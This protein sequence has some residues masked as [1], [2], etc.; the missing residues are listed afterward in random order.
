MKRKCDVCASPLIKNTDTSSKNMEQSSFVP[1]KELA[2]GQLSSENRPVIKTFEPVLVSPN[3]YKNVEIIINEIK[4][5][6]IN[7]ERK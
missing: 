6:A 1:F 4:E 3:S 5:K 7:N 2:V